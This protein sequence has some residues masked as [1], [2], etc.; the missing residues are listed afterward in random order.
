MYHRRSRT[1]PEK[2]EMDMSIDI[3]KVHFINVPHRRSLK[4]R[5]GLLAAEMLLGEAACQRREA[6]RQTVVLA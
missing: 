3:N 1:D 2:V 6:G 5:P 4:K